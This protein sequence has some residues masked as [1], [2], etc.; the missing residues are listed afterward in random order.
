MIISVTEDLDVHSEVAHNT[1]KTRYELLA[2][3]V[4]QLC[5]GQSVDLIG[6]LEAWNRG[7]FDGIESCFSRGNLGAKRT[8]IDVTISLDV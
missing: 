7:S 6:L 5:Y 1:I 8:E 2:L 4:I 3:I